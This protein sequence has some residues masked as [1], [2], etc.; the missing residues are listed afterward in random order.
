MG[1]TRIGG[2][3]LASLALGAD[4]E[5][6]NCGLVDAALGTFPPEPVRYV[7][8]HMVRSA[9]LA[10]ERAE[11]AGRRPG[12]LVTRLAALAPAGLTPVKSGEG[13]RA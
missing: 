4:D 1:P 8:A 6:T 9:I 13:D 12:A 11:D 10:K 3:I 7:G 2:R 5:W